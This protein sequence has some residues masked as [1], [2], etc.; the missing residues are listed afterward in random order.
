M[1]K[2]PFRGR[3]F[4]AERDPLPYAGVRL[5]GSRSQSPTAKP[6]PIAPHRHARTIRELRLAIECLPTGTREAML[7]GV[8]E[9]PRIIVGAYTDGE[10]GVC[11]ML[12]AHRRG[13][14]TSFL[15]FARSWDR[16]TGARR[17][18]PATVRELRTLVALLE[19]SLL[20]EE[21]CDLGGAIAE[22]AALH[23]HSERERGAR[24]EREHAGGTRSHGRLVAEAD[25]AGEILVRRLRA[26]RRRVGRRER[27]P[28]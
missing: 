20:E 12:A 9:T 17:R 25:P 11:P 24:A 10:G 22:H 21:S 13:A 27:V 18:R 1:R 14:R 2:F 4:V 6:M 26:P 16:Y 23:A 28:A 5:P 3:G 15:S 7:Q 19:G 8:R